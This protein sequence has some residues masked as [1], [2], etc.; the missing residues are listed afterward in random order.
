MPTYHSVVIEEADEKKSN[1]SSAKTLYITPKSSKT[2]GSKNCG[3]LSKALIGATM[4]LLAIFL[5]ASLGQFL[6]EKFGPEP[7]KESYDT[8]KAFQADQRSGYPIFLA[9]YGIQ[10]VAAVVLTILGRVFWSNDDE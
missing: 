2:A 7:E 6:Y 1:G 10:I 4:A 8:A 5:V 3:T 9:K